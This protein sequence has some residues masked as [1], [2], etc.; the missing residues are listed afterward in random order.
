M[1]YSTEFIIRQATLDDLKSIVP[2]FNDYRVF[3]HQKS[4]KE[5]ASQFLF[6]KFVNL[7]SVIFIAVNDEGRVLGFTQLYPSFSSVSLKKLWILNDLF[8]DRNERGK[9]LGTQLLNKA[10]EF[11][12]NSKAR[13]IILET[14]YDNYGAQRLYER[15]GYKKDSNQVF[16]YYLDV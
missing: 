13:G 16:H 7:A 3:Y 10:K 4:D 15:H 6:D 2:L 12:I 14:D 5:A 11:A 1:E 9:G 8:I